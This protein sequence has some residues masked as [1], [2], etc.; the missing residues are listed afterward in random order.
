MCVP[1]DVGES[2]RLPSHGVEMKMLRDTGLA[3][4]LTASLKG[5]KSVGVTVVKTLDLP[6]PLCLHRRVWL[7]G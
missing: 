4:D 3:V 1:E 6:E 7:L 5:L 2:A